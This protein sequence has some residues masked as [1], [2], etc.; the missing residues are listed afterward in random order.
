MSCCP[1]G[2]LPALQAPEDYIPQGERFELNNSLPVYR[3]GNSS[4]PKC[5]LVFPE[6]F[7]WEGRLKGHHNHHPHKNHE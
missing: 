1:P 6:V 7:S 2:S 5:L 3:V 4:S